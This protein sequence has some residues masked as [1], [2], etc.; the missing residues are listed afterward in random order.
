MRTKG[1]IGVWV[2]SLAQRLEQTGEDAVRRRRNWG[3]DLTNTVNALDSTT[4][5]LCLSVFP[6]AHF[7]TIKCGGE[8]AHGARPA[9]AK[10]RVLSTSRTATGTTFMASICSCRQPEPSTSWIVATSTLPAFMCCSKP[11]P[12]SSRVPS[13]T[14]MLIAF[15]RRRGD[16]SSGIVCVLTIS[17]DKIYTRQ[18]YP[19][20]LQRMRFKDPESGKTLRLHRQQLLASVSE[21]I[22][23]ALQKPLCRSRTRL[24]QDEA[25]SSD[26]GS[27]K[28]RR[29]TR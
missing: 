13:R 5:A 19:E 9:K 22:L 21:T 23:R 2:R 17:L 15:I 16:R 3:Q 6:W 20:L 24:Q 7:R 29:R 26:Q 11:G 10:F 12:S 4:I 25:A 14:S 18:D 27:S 28:A 8:D 1:A